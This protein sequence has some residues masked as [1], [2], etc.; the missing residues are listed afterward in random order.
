LQ[1]PAAGR[2]QQ[3]ESADLKVSA[4]KGAASST[5]NLA[6]ARFEGLEIDRSAALRSAPARPREIGALIAPVSN[7]SLKKWHKE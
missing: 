1:A 3:L 2:G 7:E 5:V 6:A 4:T